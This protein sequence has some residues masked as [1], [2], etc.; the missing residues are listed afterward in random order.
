MRTACTSA[1]IRVVEQRNFQS[2]RQD[3]R[4]AVAC[5][6]IAR[7]F[8]WASAVRAVRQ[9]PKIDFGVH[10]WQQLPTLPAHAVGCCVSCTHCSNTSP[11]PRSAPFPRR[12]AVGQPPL[13]RLPRPSTWQP[14]QEASRPLTAGQAP[15][16]RPDLHARRQRV[17][18]GSW[19]FGAAVPAV[20]LIRGVPMRRPFRSAGPGRRRGPAAGFPRENQGVV[21]TQRSGD[22]AGG[23]LRGVQDIQ[24]TPGRRQTVGAGSSA[25]VPA[26]ARLLRSGNPGLDSSKLRWITR[27]GCRLVRRGDRSR[28]GRR[29]GRG[30]RGGVR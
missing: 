29:L 20:V 12:A 19:A 7:I 1:V 4:A 25:R 28:S 27:R 24:G 21:P 2:R 10:I 22:Q 6:P 8:A 11:G 15:L 13:G 14:L 16:Q 26:G 9:V 18:C 5:S 23:R 3:L 17:G 30:R